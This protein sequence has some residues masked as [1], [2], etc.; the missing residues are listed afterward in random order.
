MYISFNFF[1]EIFP[2]WNR[3]KYLMCCKPIVRKVLSNITKGP[4]MIHHSEM[5]SLS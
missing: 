1:T 4:N 3:D 5:I 2:I